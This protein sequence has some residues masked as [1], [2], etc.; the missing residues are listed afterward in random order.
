M[1]AIYIPVDVVMERVPLANR[2]VAEKWQPAAVVAV[3]PAR[4]DLDFEPAAAHLLHE[5]VDG[6]QW[7]F[8]RCVV[9]LHTVEAEGYFLNLTA[10]KPCVFVMWRIVDDGVAPPA[11][12]V[13][14][15]LSYNEAARMMD[16]GEQVDSVALPLALKAMMAPFV[17]AHYRPEPKKKVRRNDP[18]GD[19]RRA[20][21]GKGEATKRS[22]G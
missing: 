12:P 15:T 9:E 11:R 1:P 19:E 7:R 14:V 16:G 21:E 2:W 10:P 17:E 3:G 20:R 8:P 13:V 5:T 4:G 22:D 18:L 6:A